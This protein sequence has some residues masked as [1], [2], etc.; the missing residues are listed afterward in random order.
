ME[1]QIETL[2]RS[3]VHVGEHEETSRAENTTP[4]II[5][6]TARPTS[7]VSETNHKLDGQPDEEVN[8]NESIAC[9]D[10]SNMDEMLRARPTPKTQAYSKVS[11]SA[12]QYG[13][14]YSDSAH[15]LEVEAQP[16]SENGPKKSIE[17]LR[18]S[19]YDRLE[20]RHVN[21]LKAPSYDGT[22]S[23]PDFLIQFNMISELN[24]WTEHEKL[25]YLGGSLRGVAREVLG[26]TDNSNRDTFDGLVRCLNERFDPEKQEEIF[27]ARLNNRVQE[28]NE[29]F[30]ELAHAIKRL[31]KN[32]YPEASY[33]MQERMARDYFID[34]ISDVS[35]RNLVY[36]HEP[37]S[38]VEAVR[39]AI[40]AQC[41][42]EQENI[43]LGKKY[44]GSVKSLETG[45]QQKVHREITDKIRVMRLAFQSVSDERNGSTT[46]AKPSNPTMKFQCHNCR[47]WGHV[48]KECHTPR[49]RSRPKSHMKSDQSC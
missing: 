11:L 16:I 17:T 8:I 34:A 19:T 15:D 39:V 43:K 13:P 24:D 1:K 47:K 5:G 48:R 28:P 26:A 41:R 7:I 35:V 45:A 44:G 36:Y 46:V 42:E 38:L 21:K 18:R 6:A 20:T 10:G 32:S 23:W 33:E 30:P 14:T 31:I 37:S 3:E 4:S 27:R 12:I 2:P 29:S 25:L 40:K 22:A 9:R 49:R